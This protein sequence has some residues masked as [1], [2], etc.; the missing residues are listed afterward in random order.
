[1]NGKGTVMGLLE[2]GKIVSF[3]GFFEACSDGCVSFRQHKEGG[4]ES[5]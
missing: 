4:G 3:S 5:K 1:M 2:G